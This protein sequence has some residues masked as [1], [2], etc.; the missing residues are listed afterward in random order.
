MVPAGNNPV[1][2]EIQSGLDY[3][4]NILKVVKKSTLK[5]RFKNAKTKK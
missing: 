2:F 5:S 4:P 1:Y 3:K